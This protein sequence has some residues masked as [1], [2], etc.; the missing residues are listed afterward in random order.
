MTSVRQQGAALFKDSGQRSKQRLIENI[1]VSKSRTAACKTHLSS[2][3]GASDGTFRDQQVKPCSGVRGL[4]FCS[5][6][7]LVDLHRPAVYLETPDV[8]SAA[9]APV[10]NMEDQFSL[11]I[12]FNY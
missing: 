6:E 12:Y 9:A 3:F 8:T 1:G 10:T 7:G 11:S 4:N 5:A 2:A